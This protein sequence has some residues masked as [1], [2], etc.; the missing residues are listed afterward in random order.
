M[1]SLVLDNWRLSVRRAVDFLPLVAGLAVFGAMKYA[2]AGILASRQVTGVMWFAIALTAAALLMSPLRAADLAPSVRL[3]VRGIAALFSVFIVFA[4]VSIPAADLA[5]AGLPAWLFHGG[6]WLALPVLVLAWMRPS[7][8]L[9]LLAHVWV[10]KASY[11]FIVGLPVTQTDWMIV[12]EAGAFLVLCAWLAWIWRGVR[13]RDDID[14]VR[15]QEWA[16]LMVVAVHFANYFYSGLWKVLL[17]PSP[18]TWLLENPTDALVLNAWQTGFLP[19]A[20]SG[21]LAAGTYTVAHGMPVLL[22]A[23]TLAG[24]LLAPFALARIAWQRWL[25]FFFDVQH[26]AIF[27]LTGIFFW[28]WIVLN[29]LLF[30]ALGRLSVVPG[31]AGTLYLAALMLCAPLVFHIVFLA[32][33]DSRVVNDVR[34]IAVTS[35]GRDVQLSTNAALFGSVTFTQSRA[36]GPL[37]GAAVT[38]AL[39]ATWSAEKMRAFKHCET[40]G[41]AESGL[42]RLPGNGPDVPALRRVLGA[43][44]GFISEQPYL[45]QDVSRVH[46]YAH[47]IFSN[48]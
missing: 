4:P 2:T 33:Y 14:R 42:W 30:L 7:F 12:W 48:P 43:T 29:L 18:W 19:L 25:T 20:V 13:G 38:D 40:P 47:H 16:L 37:G 8:T 34:L 17:E 41:F 21:S 45:A 46:Q 27:A 9:V 26:V 5:A 24:Q 22:N 32:W 36:G 6:R 39:G 1:N 23:A 3:T 10:A 11:Q 44:F 28:K 35:G 31:R 15:W